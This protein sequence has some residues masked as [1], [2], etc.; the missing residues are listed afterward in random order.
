MFDEMNEDKLV[1]K[2]KIGMF[3]WNYFTNDARVL[4]SCTAL[5]DAGYKV[6][7]IAI[8]D[9]T[10]ELLKKK[11][12]YSNHFRV[13]RVNGR[14]PKSINYPLALMNRIKRIL[15]RR[16]PL[17]V[18]F[19]ALVA[20]MIYL[21]PLIVILLLGIGVALSTQKVRVI[22]QRSYIFL[23]M[24]KIGFKGKYDIYHSNDLNTLPQGIIC[25][26]LK[27]F[28]RRKL[29]YD[30]HEVQTSRTGYTPWFHNNLEKTLIKFP[31]VIINE[32]HTRAKHTEELYGFYPEVI[33]NYPFVSK[34]EELEKVDL[35]ELLDLPQAEPILLYQGGVQIGR[36]LDKVVEATPL[37]KKGVVVFI[38]DGKI[39]PQLEERVR[40]LGL[41][42][43]VKFIPK[44]PVDELNRYTPNG[45][46]GFQVLNNVCFNHYS[47]SSNKLFE[48]M[49]SGVPVIA[50]SFPE[51]QKVVEKEATGI[52]VDSHD[53]E[54][55]AKGVNYLL[56]NP[57]IREEMSQNARLAREKYNWDLEKLEFLKIYKELAIN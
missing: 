35:H 3:V 18:I 10:D 28:K 57:D 22:I 2:E 53:P 9:A 5:A 33:H 34:P 16:K 39:K 31:D 23:Q 37:F 14:L 32:N 44:V 41:E 20:F 38:G 24:V 25:S 54:S 19:V 29:I 48:Y 15:L 27:F 12:D 8:H 26:K 47:A 40:E 42:E 43:R 11:E 6:D 4:R 7:L 45:Y 46:L 51:I 36:G 49:M 52:C 50:C 55:I 30:S 21:Q 56:D 13:Y 17:L 1:S